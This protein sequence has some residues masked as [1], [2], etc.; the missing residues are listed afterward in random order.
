MAINVK[1]TDRLAILTAEL[2]GD[3]PPF[4]VISL[5]RQHCREGNLEQAISCLRVD[6]D[7]I[8]THSMVVYRLITEAQD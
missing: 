7:K 4:S 3:W 5:A 2:E 8:R 6:A 1:P